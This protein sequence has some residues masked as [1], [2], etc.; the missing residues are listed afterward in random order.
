MTDLHAIMFRECSLALLFG[1]CLRHTEECDNPSF[2]LVMI[3]DHS[4]NIK[5]QR[6]FSVG[7]LLIALKWRCGTLHEVGLL[8]GE[9]RDIMRFVN[10]TR[11]QRDDQDYICS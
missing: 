5:L 4:L 8:V 10:E 11:M 9:M 3:F 7:W 1:S 2:A 6:A